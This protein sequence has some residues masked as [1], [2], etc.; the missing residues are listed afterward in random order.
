MKDEKTKI[1]K[2]QNQDLDFVYKAICELE[3]EILD[4]EVF[5][6]IFNEN[7]SNPKNLYLI[8]ENKN[9][10]L[11]FISFHTQNLLHHCGLVG[12][13][14]EFFI[15]QKYR[16]QGVGRLLINEILDFAEKNGL[17]SIEVTTN[18]KRVENVAI[19]ES[20]GFRLSHNKFTI[21]K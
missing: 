4:F 9:E 20:L 1:R 13:I 8:A 5:E 12:E 6:M 10:G 21:Y 3:K 15:H 14:Q 11:G 2:I 7:I 18:K 16:G 17:K 19:Y